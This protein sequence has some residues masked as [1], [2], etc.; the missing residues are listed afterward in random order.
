M[1]DIR[2]WRGGVK[3]CI[4]EI[5]GK[6]A[7]V[8]FLEDGKIGSKKVGFQNVTFGDNCITLIRH[9]WRRKK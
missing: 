5:L 8:E 2:Y 6:K 7:I 4:I 9:C 3:C 1:N